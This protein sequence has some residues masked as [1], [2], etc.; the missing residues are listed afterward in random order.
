L[1]KLSEIALK[2]KPVGSSSAMR[3]TSVAQF[4]SYCIRMIK[5]L[6]EDLAKI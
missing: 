5:A 4:K 6:K 3:I 2:S 1:K